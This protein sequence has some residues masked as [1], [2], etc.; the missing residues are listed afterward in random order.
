MARGGGSSTLALLVLL[1]II[2]GY[3]T[4]NY[5][6]NQAAEEAVPRPYRTYS[7]ADLGTLGAAYRQELDA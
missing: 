4:W 6:R 1:G 7:D 2:G 5:K 3:G